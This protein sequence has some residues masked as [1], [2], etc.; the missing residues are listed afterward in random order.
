MPKAAVTHTDFDRC[1][2]TN[3]ADEIARLTT[4]ADDLTADFSAG[5][6]SN[7]ATEPNSTALA[8][9]FAAAQKP[10]PR[11]SL[12]K[13]R[14]ANG[15]K[16]VRFRDS[17][18][19]EETAYRDEPDEDPAARAALFN[20]RPYSDEPEEEPIDQSGMSNQQIHIYHKQVIQDQDEQLDTLGRS[21]GR[22]RELSIAMGNELDDQA[23]LLEDVEQGVDRHTT[24][25]EGARKR[26]G[27]ISRKAKDNW[28]WVTIGVLVLTLV[29]LLVVLK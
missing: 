19:D 21:I 5:E 1:S 3:L 14:D 7:T 16:A 6:T 24:S 13:P 18:D 2:T 8:S 27:T 26:L 4:Q 17:A 15:G 28:S 11:S 20:S 29:L 22:Q 23:V 25:L 12:R 10:A 9:D